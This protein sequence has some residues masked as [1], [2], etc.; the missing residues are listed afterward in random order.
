VCTYFEFERN[1][2]HVTGTDPIANHYVEPATVLSAQAR[3]V[4]GQG[5]DGP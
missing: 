2:G 1:E 3:T 5:L 4:R